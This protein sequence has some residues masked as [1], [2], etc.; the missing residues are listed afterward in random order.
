MTVFDKAYIERLQRRRQ[1]NVSEQVMLRKYEIYTSAEYYKL[2]GIP[3]WA[4]EILTQKQINTDKIIIYENREDHP[5][6]AEGCNETEGCFYDSITIVTEDKS[7][8][9]F[10]AELNKSRSIIVDFIYWKDTTSEFEISSH[11]K[12]IGKT[13]GFLALEVLEELNEKYGG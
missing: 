8:F 10:E 12:G 11:K 9:T 5:Y 4:L 2:N 7:F 13:D 3:S 1:L 6:Y